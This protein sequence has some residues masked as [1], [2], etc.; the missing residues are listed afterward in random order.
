MTGSFKVY[1]DYG[2]IDKILIE[3]Y[4]SHIAYKFP[5]SYKALMTKHNVAW[6]ENRE[7]D[8][9]VKGENDSRDVAF[10]GYGDQVP[11]HSL[12]SEAQPLE[13]CYSGIVAIG[14][15]CEGDYIC[16]D[17]RENPTT[18]NPPVILMLHDYQD[19]EGKCLFACWPQILKHFLPS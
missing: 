13:H 1:R 11:S 6:L 19:S 4:E 8:F 18:K 3:N 16:F 5:L 2:C 9:T 15:S 7:F 14:Q 10:Y 17:Y 12:M